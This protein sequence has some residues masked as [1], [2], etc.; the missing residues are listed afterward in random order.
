MSEEKNIRSG[1]EATQKKPYAYAQIMSFLNTTTKKRKTTDNF[2]N[3]EDDTGHHSLSDLDDVS[4]ET[5]ANISSNLIN[6]NKTPKKTKNNQITPF[7][8]NLLDQLKKNQEITSS[9]EM[10]IAMSFLPYLKLN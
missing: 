3:V 6:Y 10:S 9:S 7:Q 4:S 1:S 8:S 2:D 5:P